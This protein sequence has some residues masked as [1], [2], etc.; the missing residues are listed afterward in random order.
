MGSS[1]RYIMCCGAR[2]SSRYYEDSIGGFGDRRLE[3]L[4]TTPHALSLEKI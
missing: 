2:Y 1:Q 3:R 4:R